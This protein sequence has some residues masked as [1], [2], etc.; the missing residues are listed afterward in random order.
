MYKA[1]VGSSGMPPHSALLPPLG[2]QPCLC[3]PVQ[4]PLC[5]G[6]GLPAHCCA[7]GSRS[8]NPARGQQCATC[9]L[10]DYA[11]EHSLSKED[12]SWLF[13]T[14]HGEDRSKAAGAWQIVAQQL[15]DRT[16]K[17]VWACGT[18][19]LHQY[20][21]K[22]RRCS[23]ARG[24]QFAWLSLSFCSSA[25]LVCAKA[26]LLQHRSEHSL[27]CIADAALT[28]CCTICELLSSFKSDC[29]KASSALLQG[30]WTPEEDLRLHDLV[31]QKGTKW[32][33]IGPLLERAPGGHT[34][35]FR[36][37]QVPLRVFKKIDHNS[38]CNA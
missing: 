31:E 34:L 18:R 14:R 3:I 11:D 9:L 35:T 32:K 5:H 25:R 2:Q 33:E 21:Y 13:A 29:L 10:Q 12:L 17:S 22:V 26:V 4:K 19:M 20:A 30:R 28:H 15:P 27:T 36:L 7:A 16:A 37:L 6:A 24:D 38:F 1:A 23:A 8:Q